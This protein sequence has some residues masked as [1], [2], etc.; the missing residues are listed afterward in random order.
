MR[1]FWVFVILMNGGRTGIVSSCR[2]IFHHM[3]NR[4]GEELMSSRFLRKKNFLH[5]VPAFC[6][7]TF[8][9]KIRTE[10]RGGEFPR[11]VCHSGEKGDHPVVHR[12]SPE[13]APRFH[14]GDG[15]S[16]ALLLEQLEREIIA[17]SSH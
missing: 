1:S 17:V 11:S 6:Q 12:R 14:V 5:G 10:H 7:C 3:K 8:R 9:T 4:S 15:R 16:E 13:R 2:E